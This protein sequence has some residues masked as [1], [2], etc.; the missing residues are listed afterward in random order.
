MAGLARVL[1]ANNR[2]LGSSLVHAFLFYYINILIII[3]ITAILVFEVNYRVSADIPWISMEFIGS[4]DIYRRAYGILWILIGEFG[5]NLCHFWVSGHPVDST[6]FLWIPWNPV[7]S[8]A[9]GVGTVKYLQI[10]L[11]FGWT[12]LASETTKV[13]VFLERN[14]DCID[15]YGVFFMMG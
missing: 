4:M 1:H 7:D 14:L 2:I 5:R 8:R 3:I 12:L 13:S 10:W 6:G 15:L 11:N 9:W